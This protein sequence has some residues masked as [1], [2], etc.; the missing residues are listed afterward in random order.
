[1]TVIIFY[2][3][4]V[5]GKYLNQEWASKK[6]PYQGDWVNAYNDGPLADGT[7]IGPFYELESV[8]PAAFLKPGD[9]LSHKHIVVHFTGDEKDLDILAKQ[10]LNLSLEQIK[11]ALK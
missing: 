10:T 3:N 7:H 5:S 11:S 8:S 6:P 9:T 4:P 2:A 1:L